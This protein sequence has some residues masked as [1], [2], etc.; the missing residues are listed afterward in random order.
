MNFKGAAEMLEVIPCGLG[1][2]EAARDVA[3]G[4][5]IDG[6]QE[7]LFVKCRPPLVDRA[8]VLVKFADP[9]APEPPILMR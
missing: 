1:G 2:Y 3:S 9:G 5:I 4:V 6:E 7:V 8:V